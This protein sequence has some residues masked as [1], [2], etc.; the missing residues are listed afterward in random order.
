MPVIGWDG[1]PRVPYNDL[2]ALVRRMFVAAGLTEQ[3][4]TVAAD[5]LLI[6]DVRGIETHGVQRMKFYL[7]GLGNGRVKP[8]AQL[9]IDREKPGTIAFDGNHGL[10]LVMG[11]HAMQ[12]VIEKANET[13]I[14]LGTLRNSSHYGIAGRYALMAAEQDMCGMSMT[15]SSALVVPTG[16]KHAALGTN[17]IGF[18]APTNGDPFCLDMA[19]STVAVG[20][21]EVARRLGVPLPEGWSV[22]VDGLPTTETEKHHAL[23]PLG[24]DFQTGGHKGYGLGAMVEIFCSQLATN[25]WSDELAR[26]H[27]EGDAGVNGQMFMAWRVDAFRDVQDFKDALTTMCIELRAMEPLDP[28][29]PVL[30][31]GDPEMVATRYNMEH[32]IPIR[33]SVFN[34]LRELAEGLGA[35]WL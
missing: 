2:H 24:I 15:N 33:K 14:C 8:R 1:E 13:S 25:P 11:T 21:V 22:D 29:K 6:A 7:I 30:V 10:G 5:S 3:D 26:S 12:R 16:A 20:K 27:G 18:A 32:G 28:D 19:T 17:P 31:A 23:T 4:A 34:E 9:S 35:A